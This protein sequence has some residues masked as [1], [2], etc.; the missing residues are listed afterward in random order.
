MFN[1]NSLLCTIRPNIWQL[2][3]FSESIFNRICYY[4]KFLQ[5]KFKILNFQYKFIT[6]THSFT[7]IIRLLGWIQSNEFVLNALHKCQ[8]TKFTS[9]LLGIKFRREQFNTNSL[10]RQIRSKTCLIRIC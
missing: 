7:T 4:N 2:I 8:N 3:L 5:L 9:Y 1:M 6:S 10:L